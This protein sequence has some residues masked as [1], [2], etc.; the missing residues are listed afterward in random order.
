MLTSMSTMHF[1]S[2]YKI[3][4]QWPHMFNKE[5][6][7]YQITQQQKRTDLGVLIKGGLQLRDAAASNNEVEFGLIG[8]PMLLPSSM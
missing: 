3:K 7:V 8:T 5:R 4:P 1:E 6:V 2:V